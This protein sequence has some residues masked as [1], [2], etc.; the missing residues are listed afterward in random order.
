MDPVANQQIA[1]SINE[2][3]T[4]AAL[5]AL[6]M[7]MMEIIKQLVN[8]VG[9]RFTGKSDEKQTL[10][11]QL[12]PEVSRIIHE[13]GDQIKAMSTV[14]FRTDSD[15]VPLI[16]SDRKVEQNVE[17]LV[18]LMKDLTDSQRR[19]ADSMARLDR[20]FDSHDKSDA[21]VFSRMTDAQN[22]LEAIGISNRESL[23]E[24]KKDHT[25]TLAGIGDIKRMFE[26]HDRRVMAAVSLQEEILS[27]IAK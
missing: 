23:I 2:P 3:V 20:S 18:E 12:D 13:S 14:M 15:G 17:K 11:V 6:A 9:K 19:L 16:Y 4:I 22:R 25:S 21:I 26:D 5:V 24:F 1:R 8:W 27:K 10:L 7:G